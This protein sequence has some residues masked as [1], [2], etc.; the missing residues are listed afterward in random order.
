MNLVVAVDSNWGI[1]Y[2]GTQQVVIPADRKHFRE[3]TG[4]GAVIVG[5]R[6]L[7]DFPGGK[8]LKNRTNII[9]TRNR[10][11]QVDGALIAHDLHELS[12]IL[13]NFD[14]DNVFVIGGDSIYKMLLPYCRLAYLTKIKATPIADRYF[15][16]LDEDPDWTIV[17][18]EDAVTE[19]GIAYAFVLYENSHPLALP[20]AK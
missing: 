14:R 18:Q 12:G 2:E 16:N 5:R 1:G 13:K 17:S 6:T 3:V 11:F 19:D 8:P 4:D 15:P 9:L 10:N 7:E 20:E